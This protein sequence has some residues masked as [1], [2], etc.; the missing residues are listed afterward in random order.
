MKKAWAL[1]NAWGDA[2]AHKLRVA[3]LVLAMALPS[4]PATP[5]T[6]EPALKLDEESNHGRS[7]HYRRVRLAYR[8]APAAWPMCTGP[9]WART[10]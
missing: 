6:I 1:G 4:A 5:S 8:Q 2:A 10:Y 7:I 3:E 9:T